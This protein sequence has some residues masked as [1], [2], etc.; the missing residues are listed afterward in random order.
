MRTLGQERAEFALDKVIGLPHTVKSDFKSFA[1][2][3]IPMS[4]VCSI[5]S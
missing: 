4:A 2:T 1:T 5:I 3:M